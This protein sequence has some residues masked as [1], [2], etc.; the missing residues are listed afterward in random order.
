MISMLQ[1]SS[2]SAIKLNKATN[3]LLCKKKTDNNNYNNKEY[4]PLYYSNL[5]FK[6]QSKFNLS[7]RGAPLRMP[8]IEINSFKDAIKAHEFFKKAPYLDSNDDL[9]N[10]ANKLI[11]EKNYGFL[12]KLHSQEDKQGFINY[13]EKLTGFPDVKKVSEKIENTF[14]TTIEK[15][16]EKL[17]QGKYKCI[18]AMYDPTCSV[19]LKVALPGSDIDKGLIILKGTSDDAKN[20]EIVNKFS[21][22]LWFNTDQRL[23][24]YNHEASFPTVMTEKQL[25]DQIQAID[26]K[27]NHLNFD[28]EH[29]SSL[30]GDYKLDLESAAEYNIKVSEQLPLLV[31]SG[32]NEAN[33]QSAERLAFSVESIRDGK[34]VIKSKELDSLQSWLE[35][36]DF[37][38]FSNISKIKSV[39]NARKAVNENKTKYE[40]R[41]DLKNDFNNWSIDN[42]YD[43]VKSIVKYASEDNSK[44]EKYFKGDSNLINKENYYPLLRKLIKGDRNIYHI[45]KFKKSKHGNGLVMKY[46][47]DKKVKIYQGRKPNILWVKSSKAEDIKAVLSE[48]DRIKQYPQFKNIDT[49]Q[50]PQPDQELK[51][52][53]YN[54]KKTKKD[55]LSIYERK[56]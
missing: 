44:N 38:N 49:I 1:S 35:N 25:K 48:V 34:K 45:P 42:Q 36:Y 18:G 52:F 5:S 43:L 2:I 56:I 31:D 12:D 17:G 53:R 51:N 54:G 11:R 33:K 4:N 30:I 28:K 14:V 50:C 16:S 55:K 15:C 19:G 32:K 9:I 22:E 47:D 26:K 23:L 3:S 29:M 27:T 13:F 24:S 41:K 37:Y 6:K 46:A 39:I 10:P 8:H 20:K 7:F 21:A 40:L